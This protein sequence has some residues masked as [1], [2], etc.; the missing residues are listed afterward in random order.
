MATSLD[1]IL[2]AIET[3]ALANGYTSV[4]QLKLNLNS[5]ADTL[6]PKLFIRLDRIEYS[7]FLIDS[8]QENYYIDLIT[9]MNTSDT[10]VSSL[11]AQQD[12]LLNKMFT[13]NTLLAGL[14]QNSKIRLIDSNLTNE[15]DLYSSLGGEGVT[16]RLEIKNVNLFNGTA[17]Y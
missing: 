4:E 7:N 2:N 3:V 13:T 11:K 5:T 10:P 1:N 14:A 17:C 8:A 16:L 6:L 15:R 12:L 9:I